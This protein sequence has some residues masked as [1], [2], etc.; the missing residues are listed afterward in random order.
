[1]VGCLRMLEGPVEPKKVSSLRK[2]VKLGGTLTSFL[3]FLCIFLGPGPNVVYKL[4]FSIVLGCFLGASTQ[5]HA[6]SF[7]NRS[8]KSFLDPKCAKFDEKSELGHF[9][10]SRTCPRRQILLLRK[11]MIC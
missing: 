2:V 8:K 7:G 3:G 1:M 5:N 4:N 10:E 11:Q 9:Q 6:E